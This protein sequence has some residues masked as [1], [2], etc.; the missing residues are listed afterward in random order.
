VLSVS[1]MSG[2]PLQKMEEEEAPQSMYVFEGTDY[3]KEP[4]AADRA[5]FDRLLEGRYL[6]YI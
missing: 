6:F 4:S 2:S 5:A 3:S 1:K